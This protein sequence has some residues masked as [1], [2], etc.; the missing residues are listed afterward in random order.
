[1][2]GAVTVEQC[3]KSSLTACMTSSCTLLLMVTVTASSQLLLL[4]LVLRFTIVGV[5]G[6]WWEKFFAMLLL[7]SNYDACS[8]SLSPRRRKGGVH[9]GRQRGTADVSLNWRFVD[10]SDSATTMTSPR[11]GDDS[12]NNNVLSRLHL[13][14]LLVNEPRSDNHVQGDDMCDSNPTFFCCLARV[15]ISCQVQQ[16]EA[17]PPIG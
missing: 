4:S 10:I 7:E 13:F 15:A 17:A 5:G 11:P 2:H 1:M 14:C 9:T 12:F 16:P 3:W 8:L 6:P